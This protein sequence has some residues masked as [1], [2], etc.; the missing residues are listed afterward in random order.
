VSPGLLREAGSSLLSQVR[1]GPTGEFIVGKRLVGH[2]GGPP[3]V[4]PLVI[5]SMRGGVKEG[6]KTK[7]QLDSSKLSLDRAGSLI[8]EPL[9]PST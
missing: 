1:R 5:S 6:L 9:F 7:Y 2:P 3:F 4:G 8:E